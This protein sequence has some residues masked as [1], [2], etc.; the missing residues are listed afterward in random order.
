[1][2]VLATMQ[3][4]DQPRDPVGGPPQLSVRAV[5]RRR[6]RVICHLLF[7]LRLPGKAAFVC[8]PLLADNTS[9]VATAMLVESSQPNPDLP[10]VW[11]R[12]CRRAHV[13]GALL[14]SVDTASVPIEHLETITNNML[15]LSVLVGPM[16]L[17]RAQPWLTATAAAL[18]TLTPLG[19]RSK[20]TQHHGMTDR[21]HYVLGHGLQ[22][23]APSSNDDSDA[24]SAVESDESDGE[25][26]SID[27]AADFLYSVMH[28]SPQELSSL[29]YDAMQ[30][31]LAA[32]RAINT[33][34]AA[35]NSGTAPHPI[36][37]D[38]PATLQ[39]R[40]NNAAGSSCRDTQLPLSRD[41]GGD[42][43]D[44]DNEHSIPSTSEGSWPSG[45]HAAENVASSGDGQ[46]CGGGET[47]ATHTTVGQGGHAHMVPPPSEQQGGVKAS[48][49]GALMYHTR[50]LMYFDREA[51]QDFVQRRG[52]WHAQV[53]LCVVLWYAVFTTLPIVTGTFPDAA[54][55]VASVNRVAEDRAAW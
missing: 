11:H 55:H 45:C 29:P 6:Q 47:P 41:G 49:K 30:A 14:L 38:Q 4:G 33:H 1:M 10:S 36:V 52:A 18:G 16:L 44:D 20:D 7:F 26:H 12:Y 54:R 5:L 46:S 17:L 51:E 37:S 21:M 2:H 40:R 3:V 35:S 32:F 13:P 25:E 31:A 50:S 22:G 27:S 39:R 19:T 8:L 43:D 24:A 42:D 48:A 15:M 9:E 23:G 28:M 53:M 34:L